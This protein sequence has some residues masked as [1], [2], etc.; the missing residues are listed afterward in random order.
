M[1]NWWILCSF[2]FPVLL[3]AQDFC[4]NE[5]AEEFAKTIRLK[6][7]A[8]DAHYALIKNELRSGVS[9]P[10]NS[11]PVK[12]HVLQDSPGN[13]RSMDSLGLVA[14]LNRLNSDFVNTGLQFYKCGNIN[15]ITNSASND[16][17]F[18]SEFTPLYNSTATANIIN[19]YF[20]RDLMFG[21]SPAAG[22][23]P[24]PGGRDYVL[25]RG[26]SAL[27]TVTHEMGHYFGLLHTH[28]VS[29]TE[30]SKER[31]DGSNCSEEGDFFCD[32]PADPSML[33]VVFNNCIYTGTWGDANGQAY[34]PDVSN[35]MSY[36]PA[37]CRNRFSNEQTAFMNWVY[38]EYRSYLQCSSLNIDFALNAA[39]VCDSPFS[40]ALTNVSVGLSNFQ[41]DVNEDNLTDYTTTHA[42][43]S[44]G[45]SGIKYVHL[46]S[47]L[48][49]KTYHRHKKV[50]LF[51]AKPVPAYESFN[52][53]VLQDGWRFLDMDNGRSWELAKAIG[54]D[55]QYSNMLR[56]RNYAYISSTSEDQVYSTG[57]NLMGLQNARLTFDLAYASSA[58]TDTLKIYISTNC[59][60][61]YSQLIYYAWGDSLKSNPKFYGE[62]IP[63]SQSWKTVTIN[64]TPYIN[65]YVR[66]KIENVNKGGNSIYIDN[67]RVDGGA[68]VKNIGF[69][70]SRM[71]VFEGNATITEGC[72]KYTTVHVPVYASVVPTTPVTATITV[73]GNAKKSHDY[74]LLDSV[75][76]FPIGSNAT[77]YA[78]IKV[79]DD[80][81]VEEIESII[82]NINSVTGN[83]FA[84]SN[85]SNTCVLD[86]YDNEPAS[87][88]LAVLDTL[89][90]NADFNNET[91]WVPAGFTIESDCPYCVGVTVL[92]SMLFWCTTGAAG[93]W[94][95]MTESLDSTDFVIMWALD[96][97]KG[98]PLGEYLIT[99]TMD[100]VGYDSLVLSFDNVFERYPGMG[101]E[102]IGVQVWDGSQWVSVW[103]HIEYNGD[104]GKFYQPYRK[105][106]NISAYANVNLKARF[107]F[108]DSDWGYYWAID[109]VKVQGWRTGYKIATQLNTSATGY[110][111]PNDTIQLTTNRTAVATLVNKSGWNYGCT[112]V[113]IDRAGNGALP[114]DLPVAPHLVTEKTLHVV[115]AS[116]NANGAYSITMYYTDAEMDGWM[117]ATGNQMQQMTVIKTGGPIKNITP[118]NPVA[119]GPT[120]QYCTAQTLLPYNNHWQLTGNFYS[121]FSGFGGGYPSSPDLLPVEYSEP[122]IG[123]HVAGTGNVLGWTTT[124][125]INNDY[126]EVQRSLDGIVFENIAAVKGKGNST[127]ESTYT[128][129]DKE[130][131]TGVNYYRLRQ[132]D[133]DG[134]AEFSNIAA[135]NVDEGISMLLYPNP[136]SDVVTVILSEPGGVLNVV[137][138]LG[139]AMMAKPVQGYATKLYIGTLP[140]GIY[141]VSLRNGVTQ[142]NIRMVKL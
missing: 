22:V 125:E 76:T 33:N 141:T 31:V 26:Y 59:G 50:E 136:A 129:I 1:R 32:T 74:V 118:G 87:M 44:F 90:L 42:T 109:N 100:A 30:R 111:A 25:L 70:T 107:S 123:E 75:V 16:L 29:N 114:Y 82:L 79:Y 9:F 106:I 55:G 94:F 137:D 34:T 46:Q 132:V 18:Y 138:E 38:H 41:W 3:F 71:Q 92:D 104:L 102:K 120:N 140:K 65:N 130:Y 64:L 131:K 93:G 108:T 103:S 97:Y 8:I 91:T 17:D 139:N 85:L 6:K 10:A 73:S 127:I 63:T 28:G 121:G 2:L 128:Y 112:S 116:N 113:T 24:T 69:T 133:F 134:Y 101:N 15:Y 126:F 142:R 86:I 14:V 83:S 66:F 89:L 62:F 98:G 51:D 81:S 117:S 99:P 36:S 47:T 54:P 11:I 56:F 19:I 115:P 27:G 135:V 60:K 12:I 20:V 35:H 39:Q 96:A 80:V 122:L 57:Y 88:Q 23:A 45:S 61:T 37:H 49:G 124:I 4:L 67:F 119:N 21:G 7:P 58:V 5:N 48:A 43:H 105:A 52:A 84:S 40:I 77:R 53:E 110:F 68:G 13:G 95:N 72:R 78:R